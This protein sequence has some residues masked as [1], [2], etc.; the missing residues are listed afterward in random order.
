MEENTSD[1]QN[2]STIN[3]TTL[4]SFLNNLSV[5]RKSDNDFCEDC[6][7]LVTKLANHYSRNYHG[8][9][10]MVV[11]C[12][13]IISNSLT[14]A[15]L[16]RKDMA[17]APINRILTGIAIAD[18]IIM[19]EYITFAYYYYI[20]LPKK[21][22]FPYWGAVFILFHTNFTQVLH[23]ISICLTLALAVWRYIAIGYPD[24]N[25]I[26]CTESRCTWAILISFVLPILL[27]TPTYFVV[28]IKSTT[29]V[30]EGHKQILHHTALSDVAA[31]NET[32]L[33]FNFWMYA[34]II[35]LLP[36]CL[37]TI[38]SVWLIRTLFLVKKRKQIL[39]MGYATCSST[40]DSNQ[41]MKKKITKPERRANRTTKM[42][43]AVLI[44]FLTTEFPQGIFGLLIGI[45]GKCFFLKCYQNFGE[46]MDLLALLN[47]AINFILYCCMNRMFRTIFG[48][49]FRQKI[50]Y[51]WSSQ[52][53]LHTTYV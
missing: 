28:A 15:V 27:C 17:C 52:S 45:K 29:I 9:L 24:K 44:L 49:L 47:G 50:L 30:E 2:I 19:I 16:T 34:V 37:L 13:G 25:N 7:W 8:Y 41:I 33:V 39:K 32:F 48:Q 38:I 18:M 21:M 22:N 43:V 10:S 4:Q 36:C 1:F 14:V 35:K 11:C 12:F 42:L 26:Y 53:D 46:I 23:T 31:H 20:D 3:A 40:D 6:D 51:K 5:Y